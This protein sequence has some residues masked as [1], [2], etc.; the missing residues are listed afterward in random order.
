M[1]QHT[2]AHLLK[3]KISNAKKIG[4]FWHRNVDGDALGSCLALGT[5][6]ETLGKEVSYRTTEEPN[7][8]FDFL[9][10]V[11]KFK[12]TFDYHPH[13]DLLIFCDTA[14]P[15]QLLADFWVWHE[16]YFAN[17]NTFVIDH[18]YSNTEYAN[19]NI[20]DSTA[21]SAC[22]IMTELFVE[23]DESWITPKVA[24]Y[25]FLWVS[26][27]TGHFIYEQESK[28]TFEIATTLV[29]AWADKKMIVDNL[30]RS[31]TLT[32]TQFLWLMITR[33]KKEKWVIRTYYRKEELKEYGVDK[34][35]ADSILGIMTRIKHD[36]V[37]ALIKIHDH[38]SSPFLKASLRS[39]WEINVSDLASAFGGWG[40]KAAAGLK[41]SISED[42]EKSMK[43]FIEKLHVNK[44]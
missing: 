38:E 25:L 44:A 21:S 17:K 18:H 2:H 34:E 30:Y 32:W 31:T 12:T 3:E 22:E 24:T 29:N 7:P 43:E 35:K 4:I 8:S 33:I 36:W 15:T 23:L 11:K 42:W 14:N 20:V 37:F 9:D 10:G 19:T 40:H 16:E 6:C 39:K 1:I 5:V 28:R 27:D 13:Y 26:T 41:T